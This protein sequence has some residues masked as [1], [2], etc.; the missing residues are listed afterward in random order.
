MEF[1]MRGGQKMNRG[2]TAYDQ[3][4]DTNVMQRETEIEIIVE[5]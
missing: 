4:F 1:I 2:F 3:N 5:Q